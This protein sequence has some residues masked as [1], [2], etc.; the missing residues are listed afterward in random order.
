MSKFMGEVPQERSAGKDKGRQGDCIWHQ[1]S[2]PSSCLSHPLVARSSNCPIVGGQ[3]QGGRGGVAK[4]EAFLVAPPPR[5]P[6]R[7][8]AVTARLKLP[9]LRHQHPLALI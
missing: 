6:L 5:P 2:C 1:G 8:R 4:A 9:P 7:S 3:P